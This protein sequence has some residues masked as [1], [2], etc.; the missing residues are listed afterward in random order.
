MDLRD[1]RQ[2]YLYD[3]LGEAH[4]LPSPFEQFQ[5]WFEQTR[6]V[7]REPNAMVLA[8][9]TLHGK[10]SARIV[11]LKEFTAAGAIFFTN[12]NSRKGKE[13]TENPR[14]E[15]LFFW[16]ALERQVRI[17]G[18]IEK[19]SAADSEAYFDQRPEESRYA[20]MAS[21]QSEE[22][23]SREALEQRL[24]EVKQGSP[25]RPEHWGGFILRPMYFEFWQ[26]RA[27]RLH[28]RLIYK[29]QGDHWQLARLAP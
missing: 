3:Q 10:P 29:K 26:G 12:Y 5:I 21:N 28:D 20:A 14:A 22:I 18:V 7:I 16:D 2:Q 9:A 11:L 13:L 15:L 25:Q 8:T 27:S 24:A 1:H 6:G 23:V 4:A 19:I 17:E